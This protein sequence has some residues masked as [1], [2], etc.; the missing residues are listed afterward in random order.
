MLVEIT[1][2]EMNLV[3]TH[4]NNA[5][6][7]PLRRRTYQQQYYLANKEKMLARSVARYADKRDEIN[8]AKRTNPDKPY[9]EERIKRKQATQARNKALKQVEEVVYYLDA[10]LAHVC[11]TRVTNIAAMRERNAATI[12]AAR[13][14]K[15]KQ[16][17]KYCE[18][19]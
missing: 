17:E 2:E 14:L 19:Y 15:L 1:Q 16:M 13:Q 4:R 9:T 11:K 7:E 12:E 18:H 10:E 5:I 6:A 3:I 8:K